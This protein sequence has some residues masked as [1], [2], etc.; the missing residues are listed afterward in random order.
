MIF[1]FGANT[2]YCYMY[3]EHL[4]NSHINLRK[5]TRDHRSAAALEYSLQLLTQETKKDISA[6]NRKAVYIMPTMCCWSIIMQSASVSLYVCICSLLLHSPLIV[7]NTPHHRAA[8]LKLG[9]IATCYPT[10]YCA[11]YQ[12]TSR[13]IP[14]APRS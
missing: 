4:I 3:P 1:P 11:M 12:A 9:K 14:A 2:P 6:I 13:S 8:L 5:R 7:G 10:I